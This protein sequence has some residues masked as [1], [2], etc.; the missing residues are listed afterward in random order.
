MGWAIPKVYQDMAKKNT[1]LQKSIYL[2]LLLSVMLVGSFVFA[3]GW[4]STLLPESEKLLMADKPNISLSDPS[5][6]I[7]LF[8]KDL[9]KPTNMAFLESGDA[10]VLEKNTGMVKRISNGVVMD[11]PML[12]ADVAT[13]DT[14]GMLGIAVAKNDSLDKEYVFLYYTEAAIGHGDGEDKCY[15]PSKCIPEFLPNGDRLY[16]Y[17]VSSDGSRL[18]NQKLIFSWPPFIGATHNGGEITV[19]PDNYIYI[20]VGDGEQRDTAA[21]NSKKNL[22]VDGQGGILVFDHNGEPAFKNGLVGKESPLNRYYGYGVRNG[23]GL[24]FDP[25]TYRMWDTENG[26]AYGD[27]INLVE[28]GFNS[29][30]TKIQGFWKHVKYDKWEPKTE[31]D[32]ASLIKFEGKGSYS[33]PELAWKTAT[34]V[35]AIKFLDSD[36]YGKGYE[37]DIFVGTVIPNGDIYHFDL[38]QERNKLDLIGPLNN[39]IVDSYEEL[40]DVTFGKNFNTVSDITVG[41]DGYLY[42]VSLNNGE[43]YRIVPTLDKNLVNSITTTNTTG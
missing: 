23:F 22:P 7:E 29:G 18:E 20:V 41:P 34:G 1:L 36:K 17:E 6:K 28:P 10:I 43:I 11:E 31:K 21:S 38:N 39:K 42:I 40:D 4:I 12:D 27:E 8:A 3:F 25:L 30:W 19:G 37:N 24:D 13:F 35:T 9:K 14:R 16:R 26:P 5:L 15:S 32:E 2:Y 33:D